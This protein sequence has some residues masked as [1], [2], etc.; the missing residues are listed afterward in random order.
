MKKFKIGETYRVG[1]GGE[2]GNFIR[3]TATDGGMV[4]YETIVGE[5]QRLPTYV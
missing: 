4:E 2:R 5:G 3:I 1:I